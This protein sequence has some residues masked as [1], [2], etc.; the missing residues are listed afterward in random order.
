MVCCKRCDVMVLYRKKY[1]CKGD[2][3]VSKSLEI[4]AA[5]WSF[6]ILG[7]IERPLG[8]W[9]GPFYIEP[10]YVTRSKLSWRGKKNK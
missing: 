9:L 7:I 1:F 10:S 6:K 5:K 2:R 4:Y 3:E 8:V